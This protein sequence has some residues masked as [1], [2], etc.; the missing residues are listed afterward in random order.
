M[1]VLD[2]TIRQAVQDDKWVAISG[3]HV[4]GPP[5]DIPF[6][7]CIGV[8]NKLGRRFKTWSKRFCVL[9]D[10]CLYV[11]LGGDEQVRASLFPRVRL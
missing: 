8:L 4:M 6:P 3:R 7:D 5:D 9:K 10:A 11:Y 1:E 2:Q